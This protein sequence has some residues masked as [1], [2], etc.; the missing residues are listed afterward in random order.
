MTAKKSAPAPATKAAP[1]P[2]TVAKAKRPAK[3]PAWDPDALTP[4]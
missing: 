4:E 3:Q 2:K 1:T